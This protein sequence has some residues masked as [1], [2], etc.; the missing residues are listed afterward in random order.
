MQMLLHVKQVL[1]PVTH[2][3]LYSF[4]VVCQCN[5]DGVWTDWF[6]NIRN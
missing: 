3:S 2:T 4:A 5:L 6:R 1:F